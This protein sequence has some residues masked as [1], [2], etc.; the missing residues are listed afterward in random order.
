MKY[1][2]IL[3]N[4]LI[5]NL[6]CFCQSLGGYQIIDF[7]ESATHPTCVD[8]TNK[9]IVFSNSITY[10]IGLFNLLG[11]KLHAASFTGSSYVFSVS[12]LASGTYF[13]KVKSSD[14]SRIEQ[15]IK[16]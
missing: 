3:I 7:L 13:L 15:I 4:I 14:G 6:T 11:E 5:L 9:Y 1:T 16:K 10:E 12:E 8:A 2:L